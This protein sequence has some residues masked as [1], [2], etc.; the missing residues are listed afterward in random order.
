MENLIDAKNL[1]SM[2]EDGANPKDYTLQELDMLSDY[3]T[4]EGIKYETLPD[5]LKFNTAFAASCKQRGTILPAIV[6]YYCFN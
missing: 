5:S 1:L 6:M 4:S 2:I 3:V